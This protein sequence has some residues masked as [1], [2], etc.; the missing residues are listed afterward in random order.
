MITKSA[1][2]TALFLTSLTATA[3]L[4]GMVG[5]ATSPNPSF[6]VI[7]HADP[8]CP[9]ATC[10]SSGT[11][12]DTISWGSPAPGPSQ[13]MLRF[14]PIPFNVVLTTPRTAFA[15]G[16]LF[17]KNGMNSAG[18]EVDKI[19]LTFNTGIVFNTDTND[20]DSAHTNQNVTLNFDVVNTTNTIDPIVSADIIKIATPLLAL[21]DPKNPALSS[22]V[23]VE[24]P[25]DSAHPDKACTQFHVLEGGGT[26]AEVL[27]RFGSV[28]P[29]GFGKVADPS[30]G[31]VTTSVSAPSTVGLL[32]I[33]LVSLMLFA[34]SRKHY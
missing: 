10:K 23:Q 19:N 3:N 9:P 28:D 1:I 24:Q 22:C 32:G 27:F 4:M 2:V 33:G 16:N 20:M 17:F 14:V 26:S 31:F 8:A 34:C 11:P 15:I 18:S 25:C 5:P 6:L 13:S 12:V 29:V 21:C 7:D 30:V